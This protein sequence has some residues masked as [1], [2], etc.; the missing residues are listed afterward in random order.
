MSDFYAPVSGIVVE[1]N[2]A[3]VDDPA[4]VNAEPFEGGWLIKVS[5]APGAAE[6]LLDRAA[7][8][9]LTQG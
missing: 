2:A 3:T 8:A 7:Y 6:G 1:V 4:V 5:V 9:A